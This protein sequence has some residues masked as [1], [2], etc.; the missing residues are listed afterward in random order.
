MLT[1]RLTK[2]LAAAD[3]DGICQSQSLAAAGNLLINGA[4]ATA[5]VANLVSQRRV[6][7]VSAGNDTGKTLTL[8]GTN[9]GGGTIN[10]ALALTNG[11]TV[12]STLDFLTVT[13]A[14]PNAAIATTIK[15]GTNSTGSTPW[16]MP[17][18]HL[19]PFNVDIWTQIQSGS[20]TYNIE[21]TQDNY[22]TPGRS[23]YDVTVQPRTVAVITAATTGQQQV[24]D[25]PVTGFRFTITAN[26]GTLAAEYT[27]A[28]IANY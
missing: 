17:S 20:V 25:T 11:G 28:G 5:G 1:V 12:E 3:D 18:Y 13:R 26:T 15:V 8:Y 16:Q 24:L 9:E 23:N 2:T 21:T 10:E 19:T 22:W 6:A 4:L 14:A 7:V 27:Q